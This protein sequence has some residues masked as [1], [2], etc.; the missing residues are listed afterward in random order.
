VIP[1]LEVVRQCIFVGEVDREQFVPKCAL[2]ILKIRVRAA[3]LPMGLVLR[4]CCPF[5]LSRDA[6]LGALLAFGRLLAL[7]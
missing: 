6:R 2:D 7:E 5:L 1:V 4:E 3:R